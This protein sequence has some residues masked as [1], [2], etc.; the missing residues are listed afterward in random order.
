M[1][2]NV[3]TLGVSSALPTSNR[4]PTSHVLDVHGHL[5]LID[6]G[7]GTQIQLRRFKHKLSRLDNI[8]ISHLHG[9]HFFGIFGLLSSLSLLN[10]K[11][12]LNIFAPKGLE[13]IL[14]S[15]HSPIDIDQLSY[16]IIFNNHKSG[17]SKIYEDK[18]ISVEAFSL[19]HRVA[20]WGFVF[21]EIQKTPNIIKSKITEYKLS[22]SEIVKIKYGADLRTEDGDIIKN[23]DLTTPSEKARSYAFCSDTI[24]LE[25]IIPIVK[26]VDLLYH[27]ATF[28]QSEKKQAKLS[29]HTTAKE[30]GI[31][32]KK[33]NVKQL[34]IGHFSARYK[35]L[36]ELKDEA[37]TEFE[38]TVLAY[39]GLTIEI[40]SS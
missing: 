23:E 18:R 21:R 12:N 28:L 25:K 6:C 19:K 32:A 17:H 27:E 10:R 38:N 36:D 24:Y 16:K 15:E 8:F 37:K 13:R 35:T 14:T 30:A 34:L 22:I 31:L 20:S 4:F 3:T 7:E 11:N 39:D 1:N 2:F 33:A 29:Y 26:E 5:F 40:K 9:D